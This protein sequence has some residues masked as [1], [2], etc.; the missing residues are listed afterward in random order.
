[1]KI[2]LF[3]GSFNPLHIGHL[4]IAE[5]TTNS[6][7][8]EVW[9]IISPQNPFKKSSDLLPAQMRFLLVK[10]ATKNNSKFKCSAI[11]LNMPVPS[12][13]IDTL[14]VIQKEYP[15]DEFYL[16]MGYDNFLDFE[17]WKSGKQILKE[18][19]ILVYNRDEKVDDYKQRHPNVTIM[20]GPLINISSTEIRRLISQNKSIHYLVPDE[21]LQE[22]IAQKLYSKQD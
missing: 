13:T 15:K 11:E 22:I 6:F 18:F 19:K 12:Y 21:V 7:V 10:A 20:N 17:N 9:F 8:N 16:I 2:G 5:Y 1:M 3:F 14:Q 4:I